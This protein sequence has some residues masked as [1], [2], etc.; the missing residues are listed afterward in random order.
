MFRAATI[1]WGVER[2][3]AQGLRDTARGGAGL[4]PAW[5]RPTRAGT[6]GAQHSFRISTRRLLR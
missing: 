5:P 2:A 6:G 4:A 1:A 3:T